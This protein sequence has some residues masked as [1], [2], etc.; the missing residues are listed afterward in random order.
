M[1]KANAEWDSTEQSFFA[2]QFASGVQTLWTKWLMFNIT[3]IWIFSV[4]Q[5]VPG[6]SWIP[7]ISTE[8]QRLYQYQ[9]KRKW[10]VKLR[11][12][13]VHR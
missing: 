1:E 8:N 5:N 6:S 2:T 9:D 10:S 12:I 4:S 11:P 7:L 3:Q 13:L